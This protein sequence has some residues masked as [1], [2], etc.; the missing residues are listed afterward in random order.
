MKRHVSLMLALVML[1]SVI[2]ALPVEA[3][4]TETGL[5]E[6]RYVRERDEHDCECGDEHCGTEL[7]EA[8]TASASV[9]A[10]D[11]QNAP[12]FCIHSFKNQNCYNSSVH[13]RV[14][15]KC[16]YAYYANHSF[17][18]Q[19]QNTSFHKKYCDCGFSVSCGHTYG[20]TNTGNTHTKY[21]TLCGLGVGSEL[22][23]YP[24][25]WSCDNASTHSKT[26][27]ICGFSMVY[28]HTLVRDIVSDLGKVMY[29][30]YCT[31]PGCGYE[32][33]V[34]YVDVVYP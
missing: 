5:S 8:G 16:G 25:K 32:L 18:Y 11:E 9:G 29:L 27:S 15:K 33:Y 19:I 4:K 20:Y 17:N 34:P 30:E 6:E 14:C 26:C 23:A 7:P 22:H 10:P 12:K 3:A 31:A 2:F 28:P 24:S 21:C 1:F 13:M